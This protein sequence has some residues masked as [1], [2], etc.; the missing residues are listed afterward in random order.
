MVKGNFSSKVIFE[1]GMYS[2]TTHIKYYTG[3]L[4]NT[5]MQAKNEMQRD[6]EK[7]VQFSL[8]ADN[9]NIDLEN[10]NNFQTSS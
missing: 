1:K 9:V 10:T 8:F 2:F 7:E 6:W 4:S 5:T 3:S